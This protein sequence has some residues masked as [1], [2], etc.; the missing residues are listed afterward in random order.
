MIEE[1]IKKLEAAAECYV[2]PYLSLERQAADRI[3]E[4]KGELDA[5]DAVARTALVTIDCDADMPVA[6]NGKT[7]EVVKLL[8]KRLTEEIDD[9]EGRNDLLI[10]EL[11]DGR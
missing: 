11:Q 3:R 5:I 2:S 10:K 6:A 1:L 4:L 7:S 9:L 8:V